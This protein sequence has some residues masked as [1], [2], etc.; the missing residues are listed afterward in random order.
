MKT[1]DQSFNR[2]TIFL[3]LVIKITQRIFL[4]VIERQR[5]YNA[6]SSNRT[7]KFKIAQSLPCVHETLE[8]ELDFLLSHSFCPEGTKN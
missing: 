7:N 3:L 4:S 8:T 1:T 6:I 5:G 2:Q